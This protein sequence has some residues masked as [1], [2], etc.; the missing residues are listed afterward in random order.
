MN[1]PS[2]IDYFSSKILGKRVE[3]IS[4]SVKSENFGKKHLS[5]R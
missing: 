4:R 3:N 2:L 1:F 5:S